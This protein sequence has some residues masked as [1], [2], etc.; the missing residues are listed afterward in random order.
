MLR[1]TRYAAAV[2]FASLGGLMHHFNVRLLASCLAIFAVAHAQANEALMPEAKLYAKAK[3][4]KDAV[5]ILNDHLEKTGQKQYA[6]LLT[7]ESVKA[8]IN[9]SIRGVESDLAAAGQRAID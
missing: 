1:Y 9:T 6:A 5:S 8:A 4:L 3:T 7:E 2:V